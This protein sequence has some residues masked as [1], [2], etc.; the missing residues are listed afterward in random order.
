MEVEFVVYRL[1][2]IVFGTFW[3]GS[4]MFFTIILEPRLRALGPEIQRPVMLSIAR[5]M[6]PAI[7]ISG[8]ITIVAGLTLFFRLPRGGLDRLFDDGWSWAIF[9]G[10]VAAIIAYGF[11][12]ATAVLSARMGGLAESIQGRPPTPEEAGQL[13]RIAARLPLLAR[14]ATVLLVIALGAMASARFV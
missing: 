13:Q 12:A 8:L 5:V 3:V 2:H 4:A 6:G 10:F 11:G 14:T 7:G 9:I 1:L